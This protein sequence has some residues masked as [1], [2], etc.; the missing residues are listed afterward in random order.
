[1]TLA[2]GLGHM[3]EG[4]G[5]DPCT[6]FEWENKVQKQGGDGGDRLPLKWR[7]WERGWGQGRGGGVRLECHTASGEGGGAE[8]GG[9]SPGR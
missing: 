9:E 5:G 8:R 1:V 6:R 2:V 3:V 7:R 4:G